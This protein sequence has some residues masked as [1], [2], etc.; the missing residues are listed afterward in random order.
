MK[1]TDNRIY[2][3]NLKIIKN[4]MKKAEASYSAFTLF[5][6]VINNIG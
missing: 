6:G 2:S 4:L 5:A 3:M 1:N